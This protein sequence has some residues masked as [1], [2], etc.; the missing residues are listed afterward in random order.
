[1]TRNDSITATAKLSIG[2]RDVEMKVTVPTGPCRPIQLLPI[3]RS[4]TEQVVEIGVDQAREKGRTVSCAKGCGACCRQLVPISNMESREL[5]RLV[6]EFPAARREAVKAR[7]AAG[8]EQLQSN[9]IAEKLRRREDLPMDAWR[10]I[11]MQYFQQGVPCPF[12]EEE[13]C[14][15]HPDRPLA[16]R[17]YLVTSPAA[18]CARPTADTIK[19]VNLP[20]KV[21]HIPAM[22]ERLPDSGR[23]QWVPLILALEWSES[24]PDSTEPRPGPELL[25]EAIEALCGQKVPQPS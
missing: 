6:D 10:E 18:N 11:G 5:A 9:G 23:T 7:F 3:L 16:C 2:G 19:M 15:I 14:S 25:R 13:S 12:L 24:H 4:I 8:L 1:M 22:L 17:E 20:A 21:S